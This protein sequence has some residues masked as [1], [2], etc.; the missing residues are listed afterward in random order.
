MNTVSLS[1][2]VVRARVHGVAT[3]IAAAHATATTTP[4]ARQRSRSG[5]GRLGARRQDARR[6]V[7]AQQ[8]RRNI[9]FS[10]QRPDGGVIVVRG[11]EIDYAYRVL[12]TFSLRALLALATIV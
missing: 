7:K 9:F 11:D 1:P 4:G 6:T 2:G 5:A 12:L 3:Y 10:L 8:Q